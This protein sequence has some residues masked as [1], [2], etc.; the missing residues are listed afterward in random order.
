MK[1]QEIFKRYDNGF[2]LSIPNM[3]LNGNIIGVLGHIG[4]G[5]TSLLKTISRL[6][7]GR[8]EFIT[9]EII[10]MIEY[11]KIP[12]SKISLIRD[13]YAATNQN[14]DK[15]IFDELTSQ[16][17]IDVNNFSSELSEGQRKI[18]SFMLTISVDSEI[19]LL[20]EPFSKIDPYNRKII[21]NY[22]I[23]KANKKNHIIIASH[24]ISNLQ[25]I[26]DQAILIKDGRI[27]NSSSI[28]NIE[29][30]HTDIKEWYRENYME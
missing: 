13:V 8:Y 20:D 7:N 9:N 5:K 3:E 14:F 27:I 12:N 23:Q 16:F 29:K 22:I 1:I 6:N 18:L 24:E 2:E 10:Y 25:R 17:D 11:D 15:Q 19:L 28:E 4:S 26:I 30:N 21:L